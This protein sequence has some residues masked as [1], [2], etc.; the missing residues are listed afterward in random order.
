MSPKPFRAIGCWFRG[1]GWMLTGNG[2]PWGHDYQ[3]Y[4]PYLGRGR[5]WKWRWCRRC[6][7]VVFW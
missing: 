1:V 2:S 3:R 4:G 5:D 7:K 6:D